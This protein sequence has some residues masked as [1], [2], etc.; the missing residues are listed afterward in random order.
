MKSLETLYTP[1]E[2]AAY[3]K[4]GVWKVY[5]LCKTGTIRSFKIGN[6]IRIRESALIMLSEQLE[7]IC[8]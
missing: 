4:L 6:R 3:L 2:A 7:R 5:D 8:A 1:Q